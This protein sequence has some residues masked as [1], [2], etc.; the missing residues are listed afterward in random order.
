M[1]HKTVGEHLV[2][3]L[4]LHGVDTVFGIPGVHTIELYRGLGSSSIRHVTPRHE[5]GAGF[6]AD[7][8]ARASGK[9]GVVFVITGPGLTNAI[10]AMAQAKLDSVPMLVV[11][12]VNRSDTIGRN[13]G[14]LHELPDQQGLASRAAL[15]SRTILRPEELEPALNDVFRDFA[16]KRPGP[17]H[18][19]I[20]T[21]V[22]KMPAASTVTPLEAIQAGLPQSA[23]ITKA[24]RL[25]NACARPVIIAGGGVRK[26]VEQLKTLAE[27]LDAPVVQTVN[28]RG[29]LH[30][31]PLDVPASPS[32]DAVRH[33]LAQSDCVIAIGTEFGET[34]FDMYG[35]GRF[36]ELKSVIR[37]DIDAAQ[38]KRRPHAVGIF[39][40]AKAVLEALMPKLENREPSGGASAAEMARNAAKAEIGPRL[41]SHLEVIKIIR[42]TLPEAL[43]VGDST[44]PVYAGN[45]YY[46]HDR[47]SG[48]FNSATGYGALGYAAPA[49]IGAQLGAPES[50][51]VCLTG[52][53]GLQF[54]LAELG[55]AKDNHAP[56][57]F[58]VWNN[59]GYQEIETSMVDAGIK[60]VGVTPQAPDFCA[61]AK[62]YGIGSAR[63]G[64]LD[65]FA[66]SLKVAKA[67]GAPFLIDFDERLVG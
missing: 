33:L 22:M 56:V 38:I 59:N 52:D 41:R 15:W 61:I 27:M 30:K 25:I 13:L 64:S 35:D 23:G 1:A 20:P 40:D 12:G 34:D 3:L 63:P 58:V 45:L 18:I 43:I 67:G 26:A 14:F 4:E 57:I 16:T 48:W 54:S 28:A 24:A 21:D 9:P 55:S 6:M 19:Q 17:V 65:A 11:S 8:Y 44:Q 66:G 5:Q 42:D 31:H 46:D 29:M 36:P 39:G 10:T 62:A 49:S 47:P 53:G 51:V 2:E 32:L 37:I 50:T 7:G 60:P